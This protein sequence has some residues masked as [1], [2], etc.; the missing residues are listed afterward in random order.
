MP[1]FPASYVPPHSDDSTS[2]PTDTAP[3][4][5]VVPL[6]LLKRV[7]RSLLWG[8]LYIFIWEGFVAN[9]GQTASRL[10][11]RAYTRSIL[12]DFAL[13]SNVAPLRL[14]TISPLYSYVIPIV[15][16]FATLA[17]ATWRMQRQDVA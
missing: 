4:G 17:Y 9:A 10:A 12:S 15:V 13:P 3:T 14:A 8:L 6:S 11:I 1:Q 2:V 5:D 16:F 7:R